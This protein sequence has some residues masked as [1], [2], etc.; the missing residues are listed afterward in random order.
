EEFESAA[1]RCI[2]TS[3]EAGTAPVIVET[4]RLRLVYTPD[5]KPPHAANMHA[6]IEHPFPPPPLADVAMKDGRVLWAAGARNKHNLGGT[7]S[8]L[9]GLRGPHPLGEGLLARD[10]WHLVDDSHRHLLIDGWA[11]PRENLGLAR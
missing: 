5:G 2:T 8:T 11:V 1:R 7:L 3:A 4:K 10:G 6:L 9:D